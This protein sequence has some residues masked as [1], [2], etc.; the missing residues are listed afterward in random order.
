M[1]FD[2]LQDIYCNS[3]CEH[4]NIVAPEPQLSENG[5]CK[6]VATVYDEDDNT[7]LEKIM[8]EWRVYENRKYWFD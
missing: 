6:H 2:D 8:E 1:V 4:Q 5:I 7:K 3:R